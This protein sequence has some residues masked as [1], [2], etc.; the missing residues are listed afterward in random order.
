MTIFASQRRHRMMHEKV[1]GLPQNLVQAYRFG[2]GELNKSIHRKFKTCI[3]LYRNVSIC[4]EVL[5][6]FGLSRHIKKNYQIGRWP[7]KTATEKYLFLPI[8]P[9]N[10][11]WMDFVSDLVAI[12][13]ILKNGN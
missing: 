6:W 12:N 3:D 13:C 9:E 11:R 5:R 1:P 10:Y 2:G 4:A 8:A 7:L